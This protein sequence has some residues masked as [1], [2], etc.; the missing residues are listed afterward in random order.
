MRQ[1]LIAG[2]DVAFQHHAH[3]R[4]PMIASLLDQRFQHRGLPG[5]IFGSLCV[6][7]IHQHA[8]LESSDVEQ[9]AAFFDT[10]RIVVGAFAA[11][12]HDVS[13]RVARR[14]DDGG[15]ALLSD[16][17]ERMRVAGRFDRIDGDLEIAVGR[18]FEAYRHREPTGH[19]AMGLRLSGASADCGP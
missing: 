8:G 14:S 1:W 19:F 7:T 13:I 11:A 6:R 5:V 17:E 3:N 16:A 15:H 4:I 18:I 2:P 10:A 9:A 12:Q